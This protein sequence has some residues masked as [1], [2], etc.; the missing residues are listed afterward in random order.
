MLVAASPLRAQPKVPALMS[1][2]AESITAER[3]PGLALGLGAA[4]SWA[5]ATTLWKRPIVEFG[6]VATNFFKVTVASV[7]LWV[8]LWSVVEVPSELLW[9]SS[10]WWAMLSG[11][12]GLAIGDAFLF[13]SVRLLGAQPATVLMLLGPVCSAVLGAC[14][15]EEQLRWWQMLAILGVTAGVLLVIR[16][17][18]APA[19][20]AEED[21]RATAWGV[22]AGL[23]AASLNALGFLV[24]KD[25]TT[26]IRDGLPE[27]SGTAEHL[28]AALVVSTLRMTAAMVAMGVFGGLAGQAKAWSRLFVATRRRPRLLIAVFIGT[29]LGVFLAQSS[30]VSLPA[31]VTVCLTST[32]PLFLLPLAVWFLKERYRWVAVAGTVVAVAAIPFL[33]L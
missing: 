28:A 15:F 8:T 31:S 1:L 18:V 17:R 9:S 19:T 10:A 12:I 7:M 27:L 20:R 23:T 25:A 3:V 33:V 6:A 13:K 2:A 16:G 21:R 24:S 14:F 29:Y 26:E 22:A 5:L 11:I 30:L 4:F 32:T